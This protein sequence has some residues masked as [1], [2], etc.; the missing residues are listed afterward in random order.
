M[1][2]PLR[3]IAV[4]DEP[5]ALRRVELLVAEIPDAVLLGVARTLP[6]AR[7]LIARLKPDAVLLD[8]ELG[9]AQGFDLID[10]GAD[11]VEIIF[12]TA[13]SHHAAT[14]FDCDVADYVLKPVQRSRLQA[15][16]D[17]VRRRMAGSPEPEA[18]LGSQSPAVV[19]AFWI[20]A[21]H[22]ELV[23]VPVDAIS[24]MSS[25]EDYVRLICGDQS[26]LM[27]DT[28]AGVE[29]R[30]PPGLFTRVHRAH[31]VRRSLIAGLRRVQP[32]SLEIR[33]TDGR[34]VPAGR[35]YARALRDALP[36][37]SDTN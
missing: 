22:G 18:E 37:R 2:R 32:A 23:R 31:L 26:W 16:L 3:L 6:E 30:L 1:T 21:R 25:E 19:D 35:V 34:S 36:R 20:R 8:I 17:K 27:R 29:Q 9:H 15:A 33:L 28:L 10:S 4:D 11:G 12:V 5:L 13:F 24:V 7:S 14:A